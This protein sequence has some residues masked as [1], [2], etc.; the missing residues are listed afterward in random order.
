M[1]FEIP[2]KTSGWDDENGDFDATMYFHFL[3]LGWVNDES[4]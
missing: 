2:L 4:G 3:N 1:T